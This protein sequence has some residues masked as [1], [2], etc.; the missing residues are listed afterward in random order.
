MLSLC[1]ASD[2]SRLSDHVNPPDLISLEIFRS[3]TRPILRLRIR[4][5]FVAT[6]EIHCPH[7]SH[8]FLTT[9]LLLKAPAN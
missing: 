5:H 8:L 2:L 9:S 4:F 6:P 3:R 1:L 7:F